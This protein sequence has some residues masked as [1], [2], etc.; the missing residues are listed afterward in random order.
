MSCATLTAFTALGCGTNQGGTLTFYTIKLSEVTAIGTPSGSIIS[1]DFTLAALAVWKKH[2]FSGES[3]GLKTIR[4]GEVDSGS[5]KSTY[6]CMVAK[7]RD[8]V[9]TAIANLEGQ[10]LLLL[11]TDANGT[12]IL[13]GDLNHPV[14]LTKADF[15]SGLKGTDK[16]AFSIAF[17]TVR[18]TLHHPYIYTGAIALT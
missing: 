1:T 14:R 4:E 15:D 13:V 16:A 3:G 11:V 5:Y 18:N 7:Y 6:E 17:Q 2:Q 8:E 10:D 12:V 9:L